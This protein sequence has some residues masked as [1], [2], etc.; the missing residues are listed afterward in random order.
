MRLYICRVYT[1]ALRHISL[2][3]HFNKKYIFCSL[4]KPKKNNSGQGTNRPVFAPTP[5]LALSLIQ[6]CLAKLKNKN[7]FYPNSHLFLV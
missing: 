4:G 2:V 7:V 5:H 6:Y 3:Q 1:P